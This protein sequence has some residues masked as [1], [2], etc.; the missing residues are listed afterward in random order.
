MRPLR[1]LHEARKAVDG[2][3]QRG[4]RARARVVDALLDL[5]EEGDLRPTAPAIAERAGV[6]LRLVFHH[7]RDLDALFEA[8]S[9]RQFERVI[10]TMR[11][12]ADNGPLAS[13]IQAFVA[14]WGRLYERIGNVRRAALLIEPFEPSL[15]ERVQRV[16][17]WKRAEAERVFAR[18]LAT[19]PPALR[20]TVAAALGGAASFSLWDSLRRQ[21]GLSIAAA[22]RAL[23]HTLNALLSPFVAVEKEAP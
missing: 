12:V 9:Q 17:K 22:R 10:P 20:S 15:A 23:A 4:E 6:S 3:Q 2:R 11:K 5:I 21:Q 13:R 16:R 19:V 8:A 18:E 7:F 1:A 14:E